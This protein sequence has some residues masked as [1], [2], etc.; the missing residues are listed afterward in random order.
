VLNKKWLALFFLASISSFSEVW[1]RQVAQLAPDPAPDAQALVPIEQQDQHPLGFLQQQR[2]GVAPRRPRTFF[3]RGLGIDWLT[4]ESHGQRGLRNQ[5]NTIAENPRNQNRFAFLRNQGN[6]LSEILRNQH[7]RA[8][9]SESESESDID[10]VGNSNLANASNLGAESTDDQRRANL[11]M[12]RLEEK[13]KNCN[14]QVDLK[15]TPNY[16]LKLFQEYA[17]LI[18]KS[19]PRETFINIFDTTISETYDTITVTLGN[20]QESLSA[21]IS[22]LKILIL[23]PYAACMKTDRGFYTSDVYRDKILNLLDLNRDS[24]NSQQEK[25]GALTRL[26]Q[27]KAVIENVSDTGTCFMKMKSCSGELISDGLRLQS[28]DLENKSGCMEKAI[29][30]VKRLAVIND[31]QQQ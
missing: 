19:G 5:G 31:D 24:F 14:V 22:A 30:C 18:G 16:F 17:N 23:P 28:K 7:R 2:G 6:T 9:E 11:R 27:I 20:D 1:S 15:K 4:N 12:N 10:G 13:Y 26:Y 8:F 29:E 21:L 3:V 25:N